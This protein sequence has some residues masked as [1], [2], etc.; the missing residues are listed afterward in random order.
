MKKMTPSTPQP[1]PG[2]F[3]YNPVKSPGQFRTRLQRFRADKSVEYRHSSLSAFFHNS[4][5][6]SPNPLCF[7]SQDVLCFFTMQTAAS[8]CAA[9]A[10]KRLIHFWVERLNLLQLRFRRVSFGRRVVNSIY[11]SAAAGRNQCE[12]FEYIAFSSHSSGKVVGS[13]SQSTP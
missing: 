5:T 10:V 6:I 3:L 7:R 13:Y 11:K 9:P 2:S 12:G 1:A 8:C 4:S